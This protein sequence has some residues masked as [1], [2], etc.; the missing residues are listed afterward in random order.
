MLP[1]SL[2]YTISE[3]LFSLP[4]VHDVIKIF[5]NLSA[6]YHLIHSFL[7]QTLQIVLDDLFSYHYQAYS[8]LVYNIVFFLCLITF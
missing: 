4:D 2:L 7:F 5:F 6:L 3:D 8:M 1:S